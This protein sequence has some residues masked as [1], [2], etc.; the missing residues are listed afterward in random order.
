[1]V[2]YATPPELKV[3]KAELPPH[4]VRLNAILDDLQAQYGRRVRSAF[5]AFAD[6]QSMAAI[7]RALRT[8]NMGQLMSVIDFRTLS[9]SLGTELGP[10]MAAAI[11]KGGEEALHR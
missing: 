1:M 2:F 7:E 9:L 11:L 8:G 10:A 6:N 4:F 5:N 3:Q